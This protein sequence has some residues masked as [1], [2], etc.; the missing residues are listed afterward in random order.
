MSAGSPCG[1]ARSDAG[2]LQELCAL[3]YSFIRVALHLRGGGGGSTVKSIYGYSFLEDFQ[4]HS[5]IDAGAHHGQFGL[6]S[7]QEMWPELH[8]SACRQRTRHN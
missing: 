5:D 6:S 4:P 7:D 2:Q 3:L 8:V 1:P